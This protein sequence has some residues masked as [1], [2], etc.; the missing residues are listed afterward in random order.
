MLGAFYTVGNPFKFSAFREWATIALS[1]EIVLEPFVGS[2]QIPRLLEDAGFKVSI[3]GYDIDTLVEV[4]D[5]RDSLTD[6]PLGYGTAISNPPY[7]SYHFA[8]RKGLR[9]EK[10][11]FRGFSSLYLVAVEEALRNCRFV[12]FIIPESFITTGLFRSRLQAIVSLPFEG[13]FLDTEMPTCLALWGP[14]SDVKTSL[15]RGDEWLGELEQLARPFPQSKENA[16]RI[17]F[18]VLEGQVGL[19]AIDDTTGPSI[20]FC[21]ASEICS[22]KIKHSARLVSRIHIEDLNQ[23]C[24]D[25]LIFLANQKLNEWRLKTE[26]VC[27]TAFKGVR[28]DGHFRRRI[29]FG[30][31]R[32]ILSAVCAEIDPISKN[33]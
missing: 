19:K 29:D 16:D 6:F 15:W 24:L 2:G 28:K 33:K 23:E 3:D 1:E 26:D 4:R 21:R 10:S 30:T 27:L 31:A 20:S 32:A 17:T 12:A 9:L 13:M 5:H 8:K 18:N 14:F 25:E 7:L 11:Y 22:E